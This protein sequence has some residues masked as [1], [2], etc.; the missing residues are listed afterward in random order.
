VICG[1]VA[2]FEISHRFYFQY[3]LITRRSNSRAGTRYHSRG[4]DLNGN[5]SNFVET[6]QILVS[7]D[8][9]IRSYLQIRGSIP[10]FWE[11]RVGLKY[12]PKLVLDYRS[13]TSHLF[14]QHLL[15][16]RHT[17]GPQILINLINSSGYESPLGNEFLNQVSSLG[18]PTLRYEQLNQGIFISTFTKNVA[19]CSGIEY[20]S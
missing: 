7:A 18:D 19:K 8:N 2:S 4:I 9:V 1:F 11:Q 5:V 10:L 12:K 15:T 6:E 14:K 20:Q 13:D 16:L 3:A 17:Y